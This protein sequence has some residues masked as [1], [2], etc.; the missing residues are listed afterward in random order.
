MAIHGNT[1]QN[2]KPDPYLDEDMQP[3]AF[4][5]SRFGL[6]AIVQ[7]IRLWTLWVKSLSILSQIIEPIAFHN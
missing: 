7:D 5:L 2:N 6:R 3:L 4:M 1:H